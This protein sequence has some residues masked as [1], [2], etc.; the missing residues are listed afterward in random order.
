ML[1]NSLGEEIQR[2]EEE[3]K[4][5]KEKQESKKNGKRPMEVDLE[6]KPKINPIKINKPENSEFKTPENSPKK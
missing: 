5:E 4:K 2:L 6:Q 3:Y 1:S